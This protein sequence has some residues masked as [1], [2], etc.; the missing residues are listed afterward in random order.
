MHLK[1]SL[2]KVLFYG[3]FVSTLPILQKRLNTFSEVDK[4]LSLLLMSFQLSLI[5]IMN[6]LYIL[7]K[8]AVIQSDHPTIVGN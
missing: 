8:V 5:L 4:Y 2:F 7:C 1:P 6:Q 3:T